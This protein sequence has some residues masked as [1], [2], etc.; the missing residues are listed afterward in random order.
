MTEELF[1]AKADPDWVVLTIYARQTREEMA[2]KKQEIE[3][4]QVQC[5]QDERVVSDR[6]VVVEEE[7]SG[8]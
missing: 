1:P 7:L 2:K 6:K 5:T 3:N 8:V 4:L